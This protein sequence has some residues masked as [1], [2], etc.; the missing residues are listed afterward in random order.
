MYV[1][2]DEVDTALVNEVKPLLAVVKFVLK[3][4]DFEHL[5]PPQEISHRGRDA[6][7]AGVKQGVVQEH[8]RRMDVLQAAGNPRS[9]F[10]SHT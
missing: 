5:R 6:V 9:V 10:S 7:A 2:V 8:D 3:E 1:R 4:P